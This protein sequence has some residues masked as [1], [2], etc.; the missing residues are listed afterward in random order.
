MEEVDVGVVRAYRFI[1]GGIVQA[2]DITDS[3][4]MQRRR[5]GLGPTPMGELRPY[6]RLL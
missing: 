6:L 1:P 5:S 2:R 3:C 4:T